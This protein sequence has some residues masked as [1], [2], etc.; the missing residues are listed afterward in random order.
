MTVYAAMAAETSFYL[1]LSAEALHGSE[2]DQ[3]NRII[4]QWITNAS[5]FCLSPI[6]KE[7]YLIINGKRFKN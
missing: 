1:E 2:F 5:R 4:F 6:I 7:I 3:Q